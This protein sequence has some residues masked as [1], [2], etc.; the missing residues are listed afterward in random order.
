MRIENGS[1]SVTVVR[2]VCF[3]GGGNC[4]SEV[5]AETDTSVLKICRPLRTDSSEEEGDETERAG[6]ILPAGGILSGG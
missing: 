6:R 2:Q 5:S 4:S 3:S 1:K